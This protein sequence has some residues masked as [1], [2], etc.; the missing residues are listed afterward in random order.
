MVVWEGFGMSE[1]GG[2]K[3][4]ESGERERGR[5]GESMQAWRDGRREQGGERATFFIIFVAFREV[6]HQLGE[7]RLTGGSSHVLPGGP[8]ATGRLCILECG[9]QVQ[10]SGFRVQGSGFRGWVQGL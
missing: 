1:R 7:E 4:R 3:G 8:L 9:W 10:G 5:E 2:N 6:L